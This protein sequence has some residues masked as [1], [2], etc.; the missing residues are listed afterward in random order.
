MHDHG[1]KRISGTLLSHAY[2]AQLRNVVE[3][4]STSLFL[5]VSHFLIGE[6]AAQDAHLLLDFLMVN[7][8]GSELHLG[9]GEYDLYLIAPA[10]D[11]LLREIAEVNIGFQRRIH[12]NSNAAVTERKRD[13]EFLGEESALEFH[14]IVV[15]DN[16]ME[17]IFGRIKFGALLNLHDH[18]GNGVERF[19][20]CFRLLVVA[21][22]G[23][24]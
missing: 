18:H 19:H 21:S 23:R 3:N 24:Q 20:A 17:M 6:V 15:G 13:I 7:L 14:L 9:V 1:N 22:A 5:V 4:G 16:F 11:V 10:A 12:G 8:T 2:D